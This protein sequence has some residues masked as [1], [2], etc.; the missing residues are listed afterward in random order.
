[1]RIAILVSALLGFATQLNARNLTWRDNATS[2]D[3]STSVNWIPARVPDS[4]FDTTIF[5][6]S[7]ITEINLS[8]AITVAA[9]VFGEDA[10]V[11]DLSMGDEFLSLVGDG[12]VNNSPLT[13]NVDVPEGG[14][15]IFYNRS[16]VTGPVNF[17]VDGQ[18]DFAQFSSAGSGT[19]IVQGGAEPSA[20]GGTIWFE[21]GSTADHATFTF[22]GGTVDGAGG[23]KA[24]FI[25]RGNGGDATF[26]VNGSDVPGASAGTIQFFGSLNP[27]VSAGNATIIVNGGSAVGGECFFGERANGGT[28]RIELF[29]NG[30][31]TSDGGRLTVGSIE[32]DASLLIHGSLTVG[33]NNL[34]TGYSGRLFDT[35]ARPGF[36]TKVGAGTF[37]LSGASTY[38]GVTDVQAGALVAANTEGSATGE[39][40]VTVS[41]GTLGGSGTIAGA[42]TIGTGNGAGAFL[43]PAIASDKPQTLILRSTLDLKKDATYT[44]LLQAKGEKARTDNVVANGITIETG[45]T[46][47]LVATVDGAADVGS[48]Y[49]VLSNTA[50]TPIAGNFANL[51]DGTIINAGGNNL[52]ANYEGGDGNDLTLTVVP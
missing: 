37:T 49:P 52:Q 9:C 24:N 15:I 38:T 35:Q 25:G 36:L 23:G 46:F 48:E 21:R 33:N 18:L 51:P 5:H 45:A 14:A 2:S 34:S 19:I 4:A 30:R 1:M 40:I 10:T 39:S 16:T 42:V 29:G 28:A 7:N 43:A 8:D 47:N 17:I 31:L 22:N 6:T 11:F 20:Y 41:G 50:A 27:G 32:G 44:Y 26:I 13:Q 12:I 3:W